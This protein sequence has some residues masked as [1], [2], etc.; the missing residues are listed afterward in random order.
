MHQLPVTKEEHFSLSNSTGPQKGSQSFKF[1]SCI[2][3]SEGVLIY[4]IK[5]KMENYLNRTEDKCHLNMFSFAARGHC[6]EETVSKHTA[7]SPVSLFK[8]KHH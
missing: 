3:T 6:I 1:Q 7:P 2:C 8:T 5:E 4:T